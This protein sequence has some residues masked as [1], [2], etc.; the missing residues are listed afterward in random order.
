M[1]LCTLE[2]VCAQSRGETY[3]GQPDHGSRQFGP[4]YSSAQTFASQQVYNSYQPQ[5]TN[6]QQPPQPA[7]NRFQ[8]QGPSRPGFAQQPQQNFQRPIQQQQRP[9]VRPQGGSTFENRFGG[10]MQNDDPNSYDGSLTTRRPPKMPLQTTDLPA[11]QPLDTRFDNFTS[12]KISWDG[13]LSRNAEVFSLKL[14]AYLE[15]L[16]P[17]QS[18]MISP[19]SIHSLLVMIAE[20]AGGKTF[21]ELNQALGL[22]SKERARDFHQY[23]ST[24]LK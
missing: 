24:A 16:Y 13:E 21:E 18:F 20:G 12:R 11:P 19:F 17:S 7:V 22:K 10:S 15:G 6:Y 14:F 8:N 5:Y 3:K 23:I 4:Q 2:I 1:F 9:T